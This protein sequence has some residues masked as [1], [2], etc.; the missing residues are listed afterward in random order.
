MAFFLPSLAQGGAELS[1][2]KLANAAVERG[3]NTDL[4]V[5]TETDGLQGYV[6]PGV[7]L[8][9]LNAPRVSRSLFSLGRYLRRVRPK[10]II[11]S[12]THANVIVMIACVVFR[13]K[14][15]TIL[16]EHSTFSHAVARENRIARFLLSLF[17]RTLYPIANELVAV[18]EGS[19]RDLSR[20]LG[21]PAKKVRVIY[22]PVVDEDLIAEANKVNASYSTV[23]PGH[24]FVLAV[25]RLEPEKDFESL[26]QAFSLVAERDDATLMIAGEGSLE[27]SLKDKVRALGL[28]KRVVFLGFVEN[29]LPLMKRSAA[30]V[31]TSK[32]E[33]LPTV[34]IEALASGAQVIATDCP[35]G[36]R[37]ILEDGRWGTLVSPGDVSGIASAILQV[38]S[39]E[40]KIA[41]SE[42]AWYFSTEK[43][44][45]LYLG[46]LPIDDPEV[47]PT[48]PLL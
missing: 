48:I 19:G 11:S 32:F 7:N 8:I 14:T 3:L 4:I 41:A 25:G 27:R 43:A 24:R 34:L 40:K 9:H 35:N 2:I 36:P 47:W 17:S 21:L 6:K 15:F 44:I 10:A 20:A 18:S 30:F 45:E 23:A 12:M 38:L 46:L 37:E 28:S 22:N 31:S 16:C 33:A 29:P 1:V 13:I 42:R 5:A 39:C 26:I